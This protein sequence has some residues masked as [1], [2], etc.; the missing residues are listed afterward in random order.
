VDT[1]H[2][3]AG[4]SG[5]RRG[6]RIL[7]WLVTREF[8]LPLACCLLAFSALFLFSSVF[9]NL[10][11]FMRRSGQVAPGSRWEIVQYFLLLQPANMLTVLP[12]SV[13]LSCCFVVSKMGRHHEL[14]AMRAT[15]IH[16]I[17][18]ALPVW[19]TSLLLC[20]A[21]F[22]IGEAL[23]PRCAT[24]AAH[25][26]EAWT[27]APE[28]LRRPTTLIYRNAPGRRDWFFESF[29]ADG[30]HGRVFIKQFTAEDTIA[31]ELRAAAV[32]YLDGAWVFQGC[33]VTPFDKETQLPV[34]GGAQRHETYRPTELDETPERMLNHVRPADNLSIGAILATL[35]ANPD[36]PEPVT[37]SLRSTAWF[38]ISFSLACLIGAL[39]GVALSIT[40]E[41]S[42]A[43]R[44]FA[45]AVAL[46][47]A[48]YVTSQLGLT[49]A[50]RGR[51][52]PLAGS[53][54]PTAAFL[55]AG[56]V[57]MYRRR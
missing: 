13:L 38:R 2:G 45:L 22:W 18:M 6:S 10:E 19:I 39:F 55:V 33:E 31:W 53:C 50:R 5:K 14:A 29:A 42:S 37:R 20:G 32:R 8:L 54:L 57:I 48:F 26:L 16:M 25:L 49:L 7:F 15:G 30:K 46:M 23:V 56:G 40:R 17:Q 21:S 51:V 4:A 24:Q 41:R 12:M 11:D 36:L 44:G 47:A 28:R 3:Q 52:P 43:M 34:E 9:D 1:D 35:R 27:E